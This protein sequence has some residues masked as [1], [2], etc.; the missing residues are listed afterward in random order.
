MS[1]D[2]QKLIVIRFV[3]KFSWIFGDDSN[4]LVAELSSWV[5]FSS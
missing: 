1:Y 4:T 5:L 2:E 3:E